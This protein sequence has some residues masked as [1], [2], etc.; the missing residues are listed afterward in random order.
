MTVGESP[1]KLIP[2]TPIQQAYWVGR[3]TD[4]KLGGVSTHSCEEIVCHGRDMR[5]LEEAFNALIRR[6]DM[7]RAVVTRDGMIRILEETPHYDFHLDDA[8]HM[9]AIEKYHRIDNHRNRIREEV[10]ASDSWPLFRV[11]GVRLAEDEYRLFVS[12]DAL[13][14]DASSRGVLFKEWRALYEEPQNPL[15]ALKSSIDEYI[16]RSTN[17]PDRVKKT[18]AAREY[19]S[20]IMVDMPGSPR[21]YARK[22]EPTND[23]F[24]RL[25]ADLPKEVFESIER[26]CSEFKQKTSVTSCFLALFS[27][28]LSKWV[29]VP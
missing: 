9:S 7:L 3:Q 28:T 4:M 6:H 24:E 1:I 21:L 17:D 20:Q 10:L 27:R 8:R 5:R 22:P 15:P 19:W 12:T 29:E 14:L 13:L 18:H 25:E 16:E 23:T 11:K 26:R 2:M